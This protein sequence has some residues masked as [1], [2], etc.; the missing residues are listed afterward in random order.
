MVTNLQSELAVQSNEKKI[1]TFF[2]FLFYRSIRCKELTQMSNMSL[3]FE[4][5]K[6]FSIMIE[7]N[8]F[9]NA[10][11][12]NFQIVEMLPSSMN[13]MKEFNYII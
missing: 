12:C 6:L 3:R 7:G 11:F 9:F 1:S 8:V 5:Y 2:F 4:R 10:N 13:V